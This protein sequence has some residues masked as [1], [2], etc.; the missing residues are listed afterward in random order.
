MKHRLAI[1]FFN[2]K[3]GAAVRVDLDCRKLGTATGQYGVLEGE[4]PR[5]V[6]EVYRASIPETSDLF[7]EYPYEFYMKRN[8]EETN[9]T[10]EF[11]GGDE[12]KVFFYV[13]ANPRIRLTDGSVVWG[14]ECWWQLVENLEDKNVMAV[15][16]ALSLIDVWYRKHF[17][18]SGDEKMSM[19]DWA[20]R[21]EDEE[22][23]N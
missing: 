1:R 3:V 15:A 4:F 8:A 22:D 18:V 7:R 17:N 23:G 19:K 14:D 13:R 11:A 20:E 10:P 9:P 5:T 16:T 12:Q 21:M 2:D 6:V